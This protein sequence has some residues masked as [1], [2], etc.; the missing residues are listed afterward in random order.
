MKNNLKFVKFKFC[1]KDVNR[2]E[3]MCF[4]LLNP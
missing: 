4:N 3:S 1:C 2:D